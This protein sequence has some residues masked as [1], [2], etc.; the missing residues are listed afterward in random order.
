MM[1]KLLILAMVAALSSCA[2]KD[3]SR[4][5]QDPSASKGSVKTSYVDN[6]S[7]AASVRA[8]GS[9]TAANFSWINDR[10]KK[11]SLN[12]IKGK[13]VLINFWATWCGPCKEELPD[14]EAISRQ[15][16]SKGLVVIGV[17][18]DQGPGLL[19]DVSSF[20]QKHGLTYQ[21]VIDNNDIANAYGGIN[22]IPTSFLVNKD[23]KI[24]KKWVGLRGKSFFESTVKSAL[25]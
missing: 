18:E 16:S 6:V 17:S 25:D 2:S 21:I 11:V 7:M 13:T 9:K 24:I 22:A 12:S 1:K 8:S 15:Y 23:G 14:I 10:G 20:A 4:H 5:N 3:S 19:K